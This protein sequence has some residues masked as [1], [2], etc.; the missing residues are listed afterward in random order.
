LAIATAYAKVRKVQGGKLLKDVPIHVAELAKINLMYRGLAHLTFGAVRLL[1]RVECAVAS[2]QEEHLLRI[3]TPVVKAFAAEKACGCME[4]AMTALG[5]AGYM[6]ENDIGRV[7]RDCLV[8][9]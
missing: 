4:E 9:K 6:E 7:I 2:E 8:E 1:G 5:G 3:L